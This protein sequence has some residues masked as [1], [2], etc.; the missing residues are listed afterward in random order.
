MDKAAP[1]RMRCQTHPTVVAVATCDACGRQL[2]LDCATPVR[3]EVFGP[4]CL[5]DV[6][7]DAPPGPAPDVP[8]RRTAADRIALGGLAVAAVASFLPWARFGVGSSAFGAWGF[9]PPRYATPVGPLAILG[10]LLLWMS[11]RP[12]APASESLRRRIA[13]VAGTLIAVLSLLAVIR[14][15]PFAEPNLV[16]FAALACG[17]AA[18]LARPLSLVRRPK[19]AD[20]AVV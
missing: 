10:V 15:E 17:L 14:P 7:P 16:P 12:A 8:A 4:E 11:S 13:L 18:A 5:P 3:G 19:R 20:R 1:G 2:C 6:L 9:S